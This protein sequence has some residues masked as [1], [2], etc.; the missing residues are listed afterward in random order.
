MK[1]Q[2]DYFDT[3]GLKPGASPEEILRAYET[4]ME[5]WNPERVPEYYK[6]K[7]ME[8][9]DKIEEAYQALLKIVKSVSCHVLRSFGQKNDYF[10]TV[11]HLWENTTQNRITTSKLVSCGKLVNRDLQ[12]AI[13]NNTDLFVREEAQSYDFF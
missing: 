9:R 5:Y 3:L 10:A 6:Q 7:A 12:E 2:K 4:L 1:D 11:Y 8:G 13:V